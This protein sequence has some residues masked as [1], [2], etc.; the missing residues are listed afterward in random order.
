MKDRSQNEHEKP[1]TSHNEEPDVEVISNGAAGGDKDGSNPNGARS[2][3]SDNPASNF[4]C[5]CCKY[6]LFE[7]TCKK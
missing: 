2:K 6:E 5:H 3:T 1:S 7:Q 4:S